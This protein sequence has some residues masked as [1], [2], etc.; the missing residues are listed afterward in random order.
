MESTT[1]ILNPS[2][3]QELKAAVA[4]RRF[5]RIEYL[6]E[7]HE[8]IRTDVLLKQIVS[9]DGAEFLE[10]ATGQEVPVRKVVSVNGVLSPN[11]PG[12]DNYSCNC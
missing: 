7:L 11:Y 6:T 8:F 12:Y 4:E 9:R 1:N 3:D 5:V 2:F 10:L